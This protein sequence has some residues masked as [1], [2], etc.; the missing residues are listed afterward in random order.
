MQLPCRLT[1]SAQ[2]TR[3]ASALHAYC[4]PT[5][6]SAWL[7]APLAPLPPPLPG[8]RAWHPAAAPIHPNMGQHAQTLA[9]SAGT[10]QQQGT[11]PAPRTARCVEPLVTKRGCPK[12]TLAYMHCCTTW[13]MSGCK[14]GLA[15]NHIGWRP[16]YTHLY[17]PTLSWVPGVR[18]FALRHRGSAPP[19]TS[20]S[21][22]CVHACG[23]RVCSG[24]AAVVGWWLRACTVQVQGWPCL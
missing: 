7:C 12:L 6:P 14:A 23:A 10:Q 16:I 15:N 2:C 3:S 21:H 20:A 9:A 8:T 5:G 18:F 13:C 22:A 11:P 19:P 4:C 17:T 24:C 1:Q